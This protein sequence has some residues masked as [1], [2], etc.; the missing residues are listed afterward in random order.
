MLG[1]IIT[2]PLVLSYSTPFKPTGAP[3][4]EDTLNTPE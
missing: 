1:G 3:G 2:V 4:A